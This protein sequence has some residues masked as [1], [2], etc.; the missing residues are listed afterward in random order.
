[1]QKKQ[2]MPSP[3]GFATFGDLLHYLRERVHLTQRELAALVGY[4]H[5]YVGYLEKNLRKVDKATLLGRFVPALGLDDKPEWVDRLI[6]LV[7]NKKDAPLFSSKAEL[8]VSGENVTGLPSSLTSM[9]G[10]EYESARLHKLILDPDIRLITVVGPPGVGKTCLALNIAR[11]VFSAFSQGVVFVDL[12]PIHN[13]DMLLSALALALGIPESSKTSIEDGI[14]TNLAQKKL[15][16]VFDNFEQIVDAAPQLLPLF[17]APNIK[18]LVTSREI[19]RLRG[20]QE[21]HL[22]PLSIPVGNSLGQ[23]QNFPSVDLFVER[24]RSVI[25]EFKLDEKNASHVAEICRRLDGLPLA[26][27]LAA[28]RI[29]TMSLA[30]MLE[31]FDRRFDWL[32]QGARDL[33]AWRQTLQGAIEWSY[34]LLSEKERSLFCRLSIFTGGWTLEAAEEVCSDDETCPRSE[35][36]NLLIQLAEKS[37]V[38][39]DIEGRRYTLLETLREFASEKLTERHELEQ[40]RK[41]HFE[42]YL[43]FSQNAKPHLMQGADQLLWLNLTEREYNN[44]R[45]ALAWA[46][47]DPARSESAMQFGLAIHI[48]WLT[49]SYIN[50]ARHWIHKILALDSSPSKS[51]ANLLRFASDYAGSQ[52]DYA[53]AR[54]LE[55]EAMQISK[56]LGDEVGIYFSMDGM[57]MLAGMMGDYATTAALLEQV[58]AYR[59]RMGDKMLLT[60]TLN[61]LAIATR[62]LGDLERAKLLYA[63]VIK[64]AK[65]SEN[66]KSQAHALHGL[67][68]IYMD[69]KEY[70]NALHLQ[71][72]CISI[73]RQLGDIKGLAFSLNSIAIST[74]CLGNMILAVQLESAAAKLRQELGIIIALATRVENENFISQLR[75][76]L[77]DANFERAW[78]DGQTMSLDQALTLSMRDAGV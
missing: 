12:T 44:L 15:L 70:E 33:P 41:R 6:E 14:K 69:I 78:A 28:A 59:R 38:T 75:I 5:S 67:A 47:E 10:R 51:R 61:N 26:I 32:T 76:K 9:I 20:E 52:G 37:L 63:E 45:T 11:K 49:R 23:Y 17:S 35:I 65:D 42:Y 31:Q 53:I 57:A 3:D 74:E 60:G 7:E 71:R 50:E 43:R 39:P 24:A 2:I 54:S 29:R 68:E 40:L 25:P 66:M 13:P 36:I 72:E 19:L 27:E 18:I 21:F 56:T 4:H 64:I 8:S 46:V 62:R 77:G 16:I 1:M 34:N 22:M 55:E 30:S 73:R 58:L 48:F